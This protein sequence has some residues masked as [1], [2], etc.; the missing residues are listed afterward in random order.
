MHIEYI[1]MILY[2]YM[3]KQYGALCVVAI[4]AGLMPS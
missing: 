4:M 3:I 1:C 2:D